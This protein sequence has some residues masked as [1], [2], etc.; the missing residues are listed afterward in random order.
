MK[1]KVRKQRKLCLNANSPAEKQK[2]VTFGFLELC[3]KEVLAQLIKEAAKRDGS[4]A[5][6]SCCMPRE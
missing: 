2:N 1:L 5:H 3:T 4:A 6:P